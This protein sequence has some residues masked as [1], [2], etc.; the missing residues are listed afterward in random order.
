MSLPCSVDGR[1]EP[2]EVGPLCKHVNNFQSSTTEPLINEVSE[3]AVV[4]GT[5]SWKPQLPTKIS[6]AYVGGKEKHMSSGSC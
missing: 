5:F 6:V 4:L 3:I 2:W 1:D